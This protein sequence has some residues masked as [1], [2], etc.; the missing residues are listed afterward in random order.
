MPGL[1][2]L[3]RRLT[4]RKPTTLPPIAPDRGFV[5]IGDVHGRA[6][7]L[8]TL[9]A[10]LP[11]ESADMPLIFLGDYID[12]GPDSAGVLR[13]LMALDDRD[14]VTCLMGN[15]EAMM[16]EFLTTP[17]ASGPLWI[18][19]GG[20]ATLRSFGIDPASAPWPELAEAL[21]QSA[22][23]TLL[24]WLSARPLIWKSGNV[25]ASHAGGDPLAPIEP[26][27]GHGLL[28]GHPDFL[29]KPRNDGLWMV[30]GHYIVDEPRIAQ[31]RISI[32]TG[33]YR[34]DRLTAA[35]IDV[36]GVRFVST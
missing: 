10:R 3:F 23:G 12:R 17:E 30:H 32:D 4:S 1:P 11:P 20:D 2:H 24:S 36:S 18:R 19:N 15:H 7:L 21:R 9:L 33:A 13:R 16:L 31:G 22:G 5:A 14:D 25:V 26:R 29:A 35:I 28:W 6:D 27:R 8:D 34:T